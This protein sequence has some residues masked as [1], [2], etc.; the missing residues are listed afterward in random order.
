[1]ATPGPTQTRIVNGALAELGS[2]EKITSIDDP[3]SNSAKRAFAVWPEVLLDLLSRHPWNFAL[4]RAELNVATATPA[5]GYERQFQLPSG[6]VRWLP[7]ARDD[8]DFEEAEREGNF[9]LTNADTLRIRY[10]ALIDDVTVWPPAFVRAMTLMLAAAMAEGVTQSEGI[11][12]RLAQ[13]A[14]D[15]IAKAK[16]IDGLET[17]RT[18]RGRVSVQSSWLQSRNRS[19]YG[20]Y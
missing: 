10:I 1:M 16:R 7:A 15:Q 20:R 13:R 4:R 9:L 18:R 17:G 6:C 3:T 14:E 5:F 19:A 8:D 2:T 12:D 11:K